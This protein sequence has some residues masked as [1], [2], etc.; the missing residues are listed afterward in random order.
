[1]D[2]RADLKALFN[3]E[4][5]KICGVVMSRR[6]EYLV[7]CLADVYFAMKINWIRMHTLLGH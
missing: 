5:V 4:A 6:I 2:V 1:M 3:A 7:D